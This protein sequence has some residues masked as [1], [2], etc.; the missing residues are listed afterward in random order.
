[1]G[2]TRTLC[3]GNTS[4]RRIFI[5]IARRIDVTKA[6]RIVVTKARR[7]VITIARRSVV[8]IARRSVVTITEGGNST[9]AA[10]VTIT[11]TMTIG[12]ISTS[13]V[14]T[15]VSSGGMGSINRCESVRFAVTCL[16]TYVDRLVDGSLDRLFYIVI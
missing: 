15:P 6:R 16:C 14:R 2:I 8:T 7:I 10:Y 1:M 12:S 9:I 11:I 13:P 3:V 4:A 5:T